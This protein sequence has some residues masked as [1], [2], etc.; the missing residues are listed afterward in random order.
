M[1]VLVNAHVAGSSP[2]VSTRRAEAA[3]LSLLHRAWASRHGSAGIS[4]SRRRDRSHDC[5]FSRSQSLACL[6]RSHSPGHHGHSG[7]HRL[8]RL[9]AFVGRSGLVWTSNG[10]TPSPGCGVWAEADWFSAPSGFEAHPPGPV[11]VYRP[12]VSCSNG[13]DPISSP[14]PKL[15]AFT[16][17]HAKGG[18]HQTM[19]RIAHVL[20]RVQTRVTPQH[21]K[22][23][24]SS[25]VPNSAGG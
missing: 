22:I 4:R 8:P 13:R 19:T 20:R 14:S 21:E 23:L 5:G 18:V 6:I 11:S 1:K 2:A 16:T 17:K 15:A 10:S 25:Q 3:W 9:P 7:P 24:G 12:W